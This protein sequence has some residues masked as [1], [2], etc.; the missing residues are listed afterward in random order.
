MQRTER[1]KYKSPSE[2]FSSHST[3]KLR[4]GTLAFFKRFLVSKIA[5]DTRG[6]YCD[7]P[8]ESFSSH[9]TKKN[10]RRT[11]LIFRKLLFSKIFKHKREGGTYHDLPS[12]IFCPTVSKY[13][14]E[15]LFCVLESFWYQKMLRMTERGG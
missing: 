9:S 1:G 14:V 13:F 3:E 12:K 8:S 4:R 10:R 11:L 15:V 7:S 2:N 5:M 6:V